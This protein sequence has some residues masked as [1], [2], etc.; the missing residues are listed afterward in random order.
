MRGA[1][2]PLSQYA[3]MAWY[4]VKVQG[5]LHAEESTFQKLVVVQLLKT[6][7]LRFISMFTRAAVGLWPESSPCAHNIRLEYSF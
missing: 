5:Q 6:F 3:F 2:P 4:S 1:I 7:P